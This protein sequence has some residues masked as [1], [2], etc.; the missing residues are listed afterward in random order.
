MKILIDFYMDGSEE[1]TEEGRQAI[2]EGIE[3]MLDLTAG[4]VK[5]L[6]IDG[7]KV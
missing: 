4:S 2:A 1:E 6:E 5:V 7:K 3:E